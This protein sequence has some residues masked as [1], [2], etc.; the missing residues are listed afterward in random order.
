MPN[1]THLGL[2]RL[3]AHRDNLKIVSAFMQGLANRLKLSEATAFDLELAVEEAS[4]NIITHAYT[5]EQAGMLELEANL[6]PPN[7]LQITLTDWGMSFPHSQVKPYDPQ[8]PVA[9]RAGGG[10]GLQLISALVDSME[11]HSHPNR[12][13]LNKQVALNV[14]RLLLPK[15]DRQALQ[16][17]QTIS[18]AISN[19]PEL[20][21]VLQVVMEK[22]AEAVQA[23]RATL[24]LID[25]ERGE[26]WARV[27]AEGQATPPEIRLK[28]GQGIAGHVAQTGQVLNIS[29]AHQHPLF[30][31][32]ID[33]LTGYYTRNML[34]APLRNP[35]QKIIGVVQL[36]NKLEGDFSLQDE[37]LLTAVAAQAAIS[38]ENT[39]LYKQEMAQKLLEREL[40]TARQ[41]Q[42]NFLPK[43][44]PSL[45]GWEMASYWKPMT[46]VAGDF[47]DFRLM[48]DGRLAI[49]I[50]DVAGKGIPAALFMAFLVTVLRFGM[51]L[52][53]SPYDLVVQSND[54]ILQSQHSRLFAT[55]FVAYLNLAT[56]ELEYICA[57]HNPPMLRRAEDGQISLL[58]GEGVAVGV[59]ANVKYQPEKAH[60]GPG[61]VLV[62]YTDGITEII[63]AREEEF[64]EAGLQNLIETAP[65]LSPQGLCERIAAQIHH[66]AGDQSSADD[67]TL[68]I[69]RRHEA[70]VIAQNAL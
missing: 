67:E 12:L 10:M 48:P 60:L 43:Q 9:S 28:L 23:E 11:R 5:P 27:M 50:A 53:L 57:G 7:V 36:L 6:Y 49:I 30:N 17:L 33:A 56:G 70:S 14:P 38:L 63:D 29:Q 66:F 31:P 51:S 39:R 35:Q 2:L 1:A 21:E 64:G 55:L 58:K 45:P 18:H 54:Y 47:Y 69:L 68:L 52:N 32:A 22:V 46:G 15:R 41:I 37:R 25:E 61:D 62:L 20:D 4:T 34:V 65:D 42:Q 40:Q 16:A 44:I 19:S 59:F 8:A 24:Y 13:I 3:V 26:C